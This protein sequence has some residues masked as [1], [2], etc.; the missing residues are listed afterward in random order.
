[1]S[2]GKHWEVFAFEGTHQAWSERTRRVV[3]KGNHVVALQTFKGNVNREGV[4]CE[5]LRFLITLFNSITEQHLIN[6]TVHST[7]MQGSCHALTR[8]LDPGRGA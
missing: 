7:P 1:M 2:K 4:Q 5:N 3:V 6:V 8:V